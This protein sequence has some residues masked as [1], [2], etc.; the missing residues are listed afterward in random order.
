MKKEWKQFAA[1]LLALVLT[2]AL[3]V[4]CAPEKDDAEDVPVDSEQ[5]E[6]PDVPVEPEE[7]EIVEPQEVVSTLVV[8]G[9]M[10]THLPITQDAW[11][12]ERGWYDF[13]RLMAAAEPYVSIADGA[14]VN[15]ETTLAGGPNY[16]GYPNFNAPDMLAYELKD[17]GFDL[18]MTSNNHSLDKGGKAVI[19]TLDVL[20]EVGLLH[21]G[22]SRSQEE[23]D[24]NVQVLDVGGISVA[25]LAYTYGTNGIPTPSSAPYAVNLF[26]TDYLTYMSTPDTEKILADLELAQNTGADLVAV[27]IHWGNEY[28]T[29]QN[30][31]QK[32]IAKLLTENGADLVLGGHPHVLQ[33]MEMTDVTYA[34]GT[35]GEAFVSYSL[36]NFI[37]SQN[38]ELTDTTVVL[39]VE[40]TKNLETGE[41]RV[42][43]YWYRPMFMLDREGGTNRFELLDIYAQLENEDLSDSLRQP[44]EKALENIHKILGPEHDEVYRQ[45][46]AQQPSADAEQSAEPQT[47]AA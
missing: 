12:A 40:L 24:N 35:T 46:Q 16:S 43:D 38:Y 31:Y 34:D 19:R 36:G 47:P 2:A 3:T 37:S 33:P 45:Q 9:D 41:T 6:T 27:M 15:L 5:T 1:F 29:T 22:T 26:N 8:C 44:L 42:S 18:I 10:M 4:G 30:S 23:Y 17:L 39:T 25:F 7:P 28:Q 21:V 14:V 11:N 32:K 20:D 13:T